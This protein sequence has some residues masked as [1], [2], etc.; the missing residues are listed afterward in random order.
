MK[1]WLGIDF[2]ELLIQVGVTISALAFIGVTDGPD[3]GYPIVVGASF[4]LLGIRRQRALARRRQEPEGDTTAI[5]AAD[6]EARLADLDMLQDRVLELEERL[7]FAER[8]LTRQRESQRLEPG[9]A[10]HR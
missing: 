9:S 1:K 5:R 8:L 2:I 6:L 3:A 4:I 7:D 10:E